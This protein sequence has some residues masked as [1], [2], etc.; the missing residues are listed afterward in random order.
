M[1]RSAVNRT[2]LAVTGL[3]LL[4]GGLL[5]LAGG[6]DLYGR[7]GVTM[8]DGWPL[9]SPD[10]PVLSDASRTRWLDR[11]WW[12]PVAIGVPAVVVAGALG[13]LYA[14]LH[15]IGPTTVTLPVAD[16]E[17][18]ALQLRA[19]TLEDA[20][21]TEAVA[22]PDV[23]RAAATVTGGR[24]GPSMRVAVRIVPGGGAGAVVDALDD[25][26]LE[27]ARTSLGLAALPTEVRLRATARQARSA[28]PRRRGHRRD[29]A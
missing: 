20:V 9:T 27:N 3:A 7:L 15:R 5:L 1:S 16:G 6:F 24:R 11:D 12:W 14:Q 17:G 21:G 19:K 28:R 18:T 2:I 26:P 4:A 29:L 13:W 23:D 10:Q 8:P 25:G 22:L